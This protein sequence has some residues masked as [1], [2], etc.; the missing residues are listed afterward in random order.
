[1]TWRTIV[2]GAALAA[3]SLVNDQ[4]LWLPPPQFGALAIA[5]LLVVV[6]P[7]PAWIALV[8]AGVAAH[9]VRSV[10]IVA[11]YGIQSDICLNGSAICTVSRSGWGTVD[12]FSSSG[13]ANSYFEFP[14]VPAW[15]IV[16]GVLGW[17]IRRRSWRTGVAGALYGL[18][19]VAMPFQAPIVLFAAAAAALGPRKDARYLAAIGILAVGLMDPWGPWTL[20]G[21][22]VAVAA[23]LGLGTWAMVKKDYVGVGVA[24]VTL[25]ATTLS[26]FLSAGVLLAAAA[27]RQP[28]WF[29]LVAGA[30]GAVAV[31]EALKPF[32]SGTAAFLTQAAVQPEDHSIWLVVAVVLLAGAA[33]A[34]LYQH[35]HRVRVDQA[36]G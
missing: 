29:K 19:V 7:R 5:V 6:A 36:N 21:K 26:A 24:L 23:A 25:A 31:N 2:F 3:L 33:V 34:A 8:I 4:L 18:A 17:A 22:I 1:V 30:I 12:P 27:V 35:R 32:G 11:G 16:A 28:L 20:V 15:L 9:S 10:L 13:P 14:V